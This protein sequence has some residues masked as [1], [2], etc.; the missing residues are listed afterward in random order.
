[1]KT[2]DSSV[3]ESLGNLTDI[4]VFH[5][6]NDK[7]FGSTSLFQECEL[8]TA[9]LGEGV[10]FILTSLTHTKKRIHVST[11]GTIAKTHMKT[12]GVARKFS[13]GGRNLPGASFLKSKIFYPK[14][15]V[16]LNTSYKN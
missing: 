14:K 6:L 8:A 16:A 10:L 11:D 1:M 7:W 2:N 3:I 13:R 4:L 5:N 9:L 12:S 15:L